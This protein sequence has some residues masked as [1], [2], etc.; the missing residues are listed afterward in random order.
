[1]EKEIVSILVEGIGYKR[2]EEDNPIKIFFESGELAA[3]KWFRR[4]NQEWS[5]KYVIEINYKD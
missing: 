2:S 5:G 4:G 3:V 1:M